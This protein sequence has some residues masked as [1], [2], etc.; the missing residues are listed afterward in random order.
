MFSADDVQKIEFFGKGFKCFGLDLLASPN[1][2]SFASMLWIIPVLALVTY[3]G[4]SFVMQ[5][6]QPTQQQ[7]AG[8]GCMK[9]MMYG[10][11]LLSAYWA[12]IM[13]AAVG[14]YWII[15]ALVGFAQTLITHKYFSPEQ[16]SAKSEASRYVT[17]SY[18]HL[19]VYKRQE[20]IFVIETDFK[21]VSGN[22]RRNLVGGTAHGLSLIHIF[23][24][25][26][27]YDLPRSIVVCRDYI[28]GERV[29][30]TQIAPA[31]LLKRSRAEI[32][33]IALRPHAKGL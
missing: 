27:C 26:V 17:V 25:D 7:G 28:G 3:W 10:M 4:Q 13:P 14:F 16:V 11:P 1:T 33:G 8:Q 20:Q 24:E 30:I 21:L 29:Y 2:S 15:S 9:V 23:V 18:T 12:Y 19:D 6:L 31:T 32:G 22:F 5:K